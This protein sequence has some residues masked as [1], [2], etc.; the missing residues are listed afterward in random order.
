MKKISTIIATGSLLLTTLLA[1]GCA[2]QTASSNSAEPKANDK[3]EE[4]TTVNYPTKP[5][6]IIV[7]FAAGGGTDIMWRALAESMKTVLGQDVV[8]VN[9]TGGS[10]AVGM[11]EGLHAKPDGYKLTAANREIAALPVLGMAP[12]K[13][14]DF[15]F[16]G[17]INTDPAMVVVSSKSKYQTFDDLVADIKA[18]PGKLN[19]A[20]SSTP[21]YYSIPFAEAANLD[22]VTI[23]FQGTGQAVVEVLGGRAEFGIYGIGEVKN[24]IESGGLRPLALMADKR[25][26]GYFKD[27]PTMK[28]KGIDVLAHAY[29]GLAAPGGT[30]DEIITILEDALAKAAKDPKFIEF[31]NKQN[32]FI[33]YQ[34]GEDF[35]KMLEEDLEVLEMV[36]EVVKRQ[37]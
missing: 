17:K 16:V 2:N 1:S 29:R 37:K 30:P 23:P 31:M 18:N 13:T 12:F 9:K 8:I 35:K 26:E 11:N 14:F 6:E 32:L 4:K 28:E 27:V 5:I 3:K 22:F 36:A 19:F 10:G 25:A 21:S 15:K 20:S 33:D 7:P 24:H 34:S